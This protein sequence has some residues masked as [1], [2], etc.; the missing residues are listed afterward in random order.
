MAYGV[1]AGYL[2]SLR[3]AILPE[4][5]RET[6]TKEMFNKFS[7]FKPTLKLICVFAYYT[8]CLPR[9][10]SLTLKCLILEVDDYLYFTTVH[11]VVNSYFCYV[12]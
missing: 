6:L 3:L 12:L 9:N 4:R 1:L 5:E 8:S 2:T 11:F 10:L 7:Y